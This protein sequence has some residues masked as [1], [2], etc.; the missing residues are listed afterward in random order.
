MVEGIGENRDLLVEAV[1]RVGRGEGDVQLLASGHVGAGPGEEFG[2]LIGSYIGA[3]EVPSAG[4]VQGNFE[5]EAIG[6]A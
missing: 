1:A 2:S 6:F 4:D 3:T 5:T